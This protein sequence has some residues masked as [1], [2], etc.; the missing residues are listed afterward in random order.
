MNIHK[1]F[2]RL[3]KRRRKRKKNEKEKTLKCIYYFIVID[4][5]KKDMKYPKKFCYNFNIVQIK[6][7]SI[8]DRGHYIKEMR[9]FQIKKKNDFKWFFPC[10][11]VLISMHMV[12]LNERKCFPHRFTYLFGWKLWKK[13]KLSHDMSENGTNFCNKKKKNFSMKKNLTP[14]LHTLP[15]KLKN[16]NTFY[17]FQSAVKLNWIDIKSQTKIIFFPSFF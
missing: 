14:P 2:N 16:R 4:S 15:I 8:F 6:L 3:K 5:S 1:Y 9:W 12:G 7:Y 10:F 17:Q 11:L 13:S